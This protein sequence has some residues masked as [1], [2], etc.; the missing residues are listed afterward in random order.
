MEKN[1]DYKSPQLLIDTE[2]D[3][4]PLRTTDRD[5]YCRP[6]QMDISFDQSE[7]STGRKYNHLQPMT[8]KSAFSNPGYYTIKYS[9]FV[10]PT[11]PISWRTG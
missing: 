2:A 10:T 6:S 3:D 5:K 7:S 4:E 8:H 1:D 11:L 9:Y